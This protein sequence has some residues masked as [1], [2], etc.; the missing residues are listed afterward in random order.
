[1]ARTTP[2][3]R[4]SGN[5]QPECVSE[6]DCHHDGSISRVWFGSRFSVGPR[7]SRGACLRR[8]SLPDIR[9][10]VVVPALQFGAH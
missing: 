10:R 9:R 3:L 4:K 2:T 6:P 7:Q 1:M 5:N 8:L